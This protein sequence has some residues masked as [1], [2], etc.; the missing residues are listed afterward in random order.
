V[1][2]AELNKAIQAANDQAR[3]YRVMWEA[4]KARLFEL[5]A[6]NGNLR[7]ELRLARRPLWRK[8]WD[9]IRGNK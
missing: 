4:E 2:K 3:A 8:A 9:A 7:H 5:S 6:T 1:N